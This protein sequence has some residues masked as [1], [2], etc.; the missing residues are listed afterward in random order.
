MV[1]RTPPKLPVILLKRYRRDG[2][3]VLGKFRTIGALLD[4]LPKRPGDCI[5]HYYDDL[6]FVDFVLVAE[7]EETGEIL[8]SFQ[9]TVDGE[10]VGTDQ[11][12]NSFKYIKKG[13]Q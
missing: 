4:D 10:L 6:G 1:R 8:Y 3:C 13:G 2:G 9:P 7:V 11:F 12:G 5:P